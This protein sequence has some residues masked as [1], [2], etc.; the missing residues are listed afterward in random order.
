MDDVT[1]VRQGA[2]FYIA[3]LTVDEKN[4][5]ITYGNSHFPQ[6]CRPWI[7]VSNN[8][9]NSYSDS[10]TM[11]PI[12]TR[13]TVTSPTQVYFKNGDRD[14][15]VDC[16]TIASIPRAMIKQ[17]SYIGN[18]SNKLWSK[19]NRALTL[20]FG[21]VDF[22]DTTETT[23][24]ETSVDADTT[25]MT[26]DTFTEMIIEATERADIR[27]I[28]INKIADVLVNGFTNEHMIN[29]TTANIV[30]NAVVVNDDSEEDDAIKND[31]MYDPVVI[32]L[33]KFVKKN[34]DNITIKNVVN[35]ETENTE[36]K[37]TTKIV[38]NAVKNPTGRGRK[39]MSDSMCLEFFA[40]AEK[41]TIE[42]LN[43]KYAGYCYCK[44]RTELLKKI[45]KQR[46]RLVKKGV[47]NA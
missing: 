10:I 29:N 31:D 41:M 24:T 11:V 36:E 22:D 42:E 40:D 9:H 16:S 44:N 14:Q 3:D 45:S 6:K 1:L 32:S 43:A 28:I 13:T 47:I 26:E 39:H 18:V 23:N 20:H 21:V 2:I 27:N 15:V 46:T 38:K 12:Y 30:T 17:G 33:D 4:K 34:N 25:P 35:T 19:I 5:S 37:K 7:I 8:K